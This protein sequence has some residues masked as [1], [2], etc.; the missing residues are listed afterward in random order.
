M[1]LQ[2]HNPS[3]SAAYA[4]TTIHCGYIQVVHPGVIIKNPLQS[5]SGGERWLN[6][7]GLLKKNI[8]MVKNYGASLKSGGAAAP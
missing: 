8:S 6:Q 5:L 2:P 4:V 3:L 7:V 1:G